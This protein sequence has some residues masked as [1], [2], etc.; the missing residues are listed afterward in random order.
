MFAT[1]PG[2]IAEVCAVA[3]TLSLDDKLC[4]VKTDAVGSVT[5]AKGHVSTEK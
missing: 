3:A 1:L 2:D 4:C 5:P